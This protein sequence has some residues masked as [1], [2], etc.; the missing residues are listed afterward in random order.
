LSLIPEKT[1][2]GEALS[3]LKRWASGK[4]LDM[5]EDHEVL[6]KVIG[7]LQSFLP[8]NINISP[9]T[10]METELSID[11]LKSMEILANLEDSFDISIPINVLSKVRTVRDLALQVQ[12]L[13]ESG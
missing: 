10:D 7:I 13:I 9:D 6:Q 3:G 2:Q 5:K 4:G 12:K 11:S 1:V 8:N